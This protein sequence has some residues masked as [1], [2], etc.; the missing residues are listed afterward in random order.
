MPRTVTEYDRRMH[1]VLN[2]IDRH[3]DHEKSNSSN[4]R[5]SR[6]P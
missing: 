1:A 3:L 4:W 5:V 6:T 2:Y